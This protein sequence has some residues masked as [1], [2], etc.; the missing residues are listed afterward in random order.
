MS[1]VFFTSM[2]QKY[3]NHCGHFM[4]KSF[5]KHLPEHR[6]HVY[7]EN[8]IPNNNVELM[9]WNLG[10]DYINFTKKWPE[11]SSVAKFAKKG[12]SVIH[13]MN[14]I[15]CN[16]IIWLDADTIIQEKFDK[17]LYDVVLNKKNLSTHLSVWHEHKG[18]TYHSCETGFFVLNKTHKNF[19]KFKNEY[20]KIY[21]NEDTDNLRRFYDGDVYG[22]V[23][24]RLG[25]KYMNNLNPSSKYKTPM[26][27]SI[28]KDYLSHY[29]GK[30]TKTQ[31]FS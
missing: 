13:A 8:F 2:N 21:V 20:T 4:I 10:N 7:N 11:K 28:L 18:K 16:F 6:L 14:N 5:E 30:S 22:E 26:R 31:A 27:H 29:K 17:N 12:F 1:I 9:D 23:V 25:D 24:N 3:Y 19:T 15:D